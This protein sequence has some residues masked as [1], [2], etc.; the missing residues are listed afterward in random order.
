M[1]WKI[2][3]IAYKSKFEITLMKKIFHTL[4][5]TTL[6][7]STAA[8]NG[9]KRLNPYAGIPAQENQIEESVHLPDEVITHH[10]AVLCQ[11]KEKNVLMKVCKQFQQCLQNGRDQVIAANPW[12]VSYVDHKKAIFH[13]VRI[14]NAYP[15]G[16]REDKYW[17]VQK[18]FEN[19]YIQSRVFITNVLGET[20]LQYAVAKKNEAMI[21]L[22]K[23]SIK[24]CFDDANP[25]AIKDLIN[26]YI[27]E[28]KPN[29]A[30]LHEAVY[31]G[32]EVEVERLLALE[33]TNPNLALAHNDVTPLFIAAHEGHAEIAKLLLAAGK[34][35]INQAGEHGR[36]PL[37][38]AS[39][40][41]HAE[42][43]KLLINA[44]AKV[45][46][47]DKNRLTPLSNAVQQGHTEIV[48]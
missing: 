22:L 35:D 27:N 9:M 37:F 46:P 18:L 21:D 45:H 31:Q 8:I 14:D 6:I 34:I 5:I 42:I 2:S 38:A 39:E 41:G 17:L 43:V 10:I 1:I 29:I 13:A 25:S 47:K 3:L 11:P 32:D 28:P 30:P 26:N 7:V 4:L 12:T 24:N 40:K 19:K 44:G 36:S 48:K 16:V 23:K 33:G 20:P 15:G